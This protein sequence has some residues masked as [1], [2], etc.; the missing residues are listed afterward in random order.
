MKHQYLEKLN[1]WYGSHGVQ[2]YEILNEYESGVLLLIAY[3]KQPSKT[4][5]CDIARIFMVGD[6]V[7]ISVDA[8][9]NGELTMDSMLNL[10]KTA[11]MVSQ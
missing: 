2:R 11:I 6:V 3:R 10:I 1:E 4:L 5:I 7:E 9:D 8:S